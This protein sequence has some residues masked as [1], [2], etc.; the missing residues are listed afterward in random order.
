MPRR[1]KLCD[2]QRTLTI[3][4]V[5]RITKGLPST[6]NFP[7]FCVA[8]PFGRET[9]LCPAAAVLAIPDR[10]VQ[11]ARKSF[12]IA[13]MVRDIRDLLEVNSGTDGGE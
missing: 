4:E 12:I 10:R 5:R 8:N 11:K 9:V 3:E 2:Q 1:I 6:S 7:F 13:R